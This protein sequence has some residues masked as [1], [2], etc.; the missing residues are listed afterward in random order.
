VSIAVVFVEPSPTVNP[1]VT[2]FVV[3]LHH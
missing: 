2:E 1:V 3:S